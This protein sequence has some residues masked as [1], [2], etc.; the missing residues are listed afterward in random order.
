MTGPPLAPERHRSLGPNFAARGI[1]RWEACRRSLAPA[2]GE[3]CRQVTAMAT[4]AGHPEARPSVP[5]ALGAASNEARGVRVPRHRVTSVVWEGSVRG[6]GARGSAA[7][8]AGRALLFYQDFDE[9]VDEV[10]C[11]GRQAGRRLSKPSFILAD[12]L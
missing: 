9:R 2:R 6:H 12:I 10:M 1:D 11:G 4:K 8:G 5:P 7:A 3:V